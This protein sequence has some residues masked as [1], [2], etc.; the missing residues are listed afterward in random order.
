MYLTFSV[1]I[2]QSLN[3]IEGLYARGLFRLLAGLQALMV[4]DLKWLHLNLLFLL[5]DCVIFCTF[6]QLD[7]T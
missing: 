5:T 2:R 6:L 4:E 3:V 1:L 7:Q